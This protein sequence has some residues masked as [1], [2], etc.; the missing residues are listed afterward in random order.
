ML[1]LVKPHCRM[2]ATSWRIISLFT[3]PKFLSK[4]SVSESE[5]IVF[6]GVWK[7]LGLLLFLPAA[8]ATSERAFQHPKARKTYLRTTRADTRGDKLYIT[9]GPGRMKIRTLI[10]IVCQHNN[11]SISWS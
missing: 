4:L 3:T 11:L 5:N 6:Q 8:N 1:P 2:F 9:P 10:V 7:V